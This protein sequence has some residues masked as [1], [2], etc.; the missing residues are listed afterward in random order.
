MQLLLITIKSKTALPLWTMCST[1]VQVGLFHTTE[2]RLPYYCL[3]VGPMVAH[4]TIALRLSHMYTANDQAAK[5]RIVCG[6]VDAAGVTGTNVRFSM[7][8][9]S[10]QAER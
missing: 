2:D 8:L 7:S 9:V 10:W 4:K 1:R 3:V 6:T 5:G